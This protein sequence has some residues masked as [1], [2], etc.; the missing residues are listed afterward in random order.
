MNLYNYFVSLFTLSEVLLLV[1]KRSKKTSAKSQNDSK[2]LLL[3]WITIF[4]CLTAGYVTA[5]AHIWISGD[6]FLVETTGI[7]IIVAGFIIRWV[8][9]IQLGNMFT[10]DVSISNAHIL[11]TD[12]IYKIAR[13]PSYLGLI[14]I[15]SG[16][17]LLMNNVL[18]IAIII[19]PIF[20][21]VNYRISVEELALTKEFGHEYQQYKYKVKKIIPLLY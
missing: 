14:L 3:L 15:V 13:H 18:S 17:S 1:L 2:S 8:A 11:K 12:G 21:A 20:G 4:C 9:I 5:T 19:I 7:S 6:P 10:V 16:L